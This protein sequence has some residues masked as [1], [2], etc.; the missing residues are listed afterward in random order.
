[1]MP[2]LYYIV[3]KEPRVIINKKYHIVTLKELTKNREEDYYCT[4]SDLFAF[5]DNFLFILLKGP[6]V[7][8]IM[9][10]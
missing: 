8:S 1:M 9:Y 10:M 6:T 5:V 3:T 7:R 4:Y 2:E